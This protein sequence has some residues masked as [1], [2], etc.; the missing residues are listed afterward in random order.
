MEGKMKIWTILATI[1]MVV[2]IG[3]SIWLYFQNK[4]LKNQ[5]STAQTQTDQANQKI[6][7]AAPKVELLSLFFNGQ[8]DPNLI[9]KAEAVVQKINN[10]TITADFSAFKNT[11]KNAD[12]TKMFQD[13]LSAETT[14]LK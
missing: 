5:V 3:T 13:T 9:T 14:D 4:D 12:P 10:A 6:A 2:F 8:N 7:K 1:L 11:G